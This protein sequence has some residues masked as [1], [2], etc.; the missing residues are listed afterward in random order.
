M[1]KAIPKEKFEKLKDDI[2]AVIDKAHTEGC[3]DGYSK[4]LAR[5]KMR[6]DYGRGFATANLSESWR[7]ELLAFIPES[8][9]KKMVREEFDGT[10]ADAYL[11][12]RQK[13]IDEMYAF[14]QEEAHDVMHRKTEAVIQEDMENLKDKGAD[15]CAFDLGFGN[16]AMF[17]NGHMARPS[18][19]LF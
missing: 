11:E 18:D 5:M 7:E 1:K 6:G 8:N 17:V 13:A 2:L 4:E 12:G 16:I 9:L 15:V 14:L 3:K 10:Y 19:F